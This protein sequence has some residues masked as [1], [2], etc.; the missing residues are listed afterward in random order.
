MPKPPQVSASPRRTGVGVSAAPARHDPDPTAARVAPDGSWGARRVGGCQTKAGQGGGSMVGAVWGGGQRAP[1]ALDSG[2]A[3]PRPGSRGHPAAGSRARSAHVSLENSLCLSPRPIFSSHLQFKP[4]QVDPARHFFPPPNG[5]NSDGFSLT[6]GETG[7]PP[8]AVPL[9]RR[10][11][12]PVAGAALTGGFLGAPPGPGGWRWLPALRS[13]QPPGSDPLAAS[14]MLYIHLHMVGGGAAVIRLPQ[15]ERLPWTI[16]KCWKRWSMFG[17]TQRAQS[18]GVSGASCY[19]T[20]PCQE[21]AIYAKLLSRVISFLLTAGPVR[22][23][24]EMLH[25]RV[26]LGAGDNGCCHQHQEHRSPRERIHQ[27]LCP[28]VL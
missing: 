4:R 2:P 12:A 3:V 28:A 7:L 15:W 6:L 25:R 9:S 24:W 17:A 16:F 18:P 27:E 21:R 23:G 8:P 13:Q 14:R 26:A 10:G 1:T 11:P 22:A 19:L 5:V 20:S